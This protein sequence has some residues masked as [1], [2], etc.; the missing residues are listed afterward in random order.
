MMKKLFISLLLIVSIVSPIFA[1]SWYWIGYTP[2]GSQFYIDNS[3]VQKNANY[4]LVWTKVV[5]SDGHR[6]IEK[7]FI[8]RPAKKFTLMS[9]IRYNADGDITYYHDYTKPH[10]L[11]IIPG[12][13]T[14]SL[15]RHIW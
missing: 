13:M 15:Y 1:A 5:T 4:A 14:E 10:W 2:N 12:T 6:D 11:S 7:L 3:S 8:S 9:I